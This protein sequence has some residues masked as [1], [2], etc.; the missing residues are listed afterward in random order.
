VSTGREQG[1]PSQLSPFRLLAEKLTA[2]R[3]AQIIVAATLAMTV[4]GGVL[5]WLVDGDEFPELG[6]S[7]WWALQTVTTVGYGDVVPE[8]TGGR[9]IGAVL[10]LQGIAFVTVITAAVTASLIEQARR[11]RRPPND[12]AIG[13][14]LDRIESRLAAIEQALD[15]ESPDSGEARRPPSAQDR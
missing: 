8:Q 12:S 7:L 14:Q 9:L 6:T 1:P 10:M 5:V 11:R 3:A 15:R 4:A 2:R 13:D